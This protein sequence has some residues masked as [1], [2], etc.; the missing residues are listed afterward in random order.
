[1]CHD[2]SSQTGTQRRTFLQTLAG[3]VSA[4]VLP[5]R[6]GADNKR[7]EIRHILPVVSDTEFAIS[8]SL[9]SPRAN[10]SLIVGEHSFAGEQRDS[11]GQFW[12]VRAHGLNP[13]S[14]YQLQLKDE[15]GPLGTPWPLKTFPRPQDAVDS[16][17]LL[18]FTCA[19]GGDGFG[20][21]GRQFFKPHTFRQR[22]FEAALNQQPDAAIA[23]GDHIYWD[24]R[25]GSK[26]GVGRKSV[27]IKYLAG[28]YLQFKYG[29][30][31]RTQALLGT[32]NEKILT[33]IG[34]EQIADL[35]GTRFKSMPTYFVADDHDYFE[36][37]DAD[38][39]LV[40]FPPDEFS[41]AAHAAIAQLYYPPLPNA[42]DKESNRSFGSI[43]Y[44]KL[45]ESPIFDCAGYL[46]LD[47]E[48]AGLIP[49]SVER[50][51][52][53]RSANS[54]ATHFAFAPSH[55]F[56]WTAG[57]WREWYPD[58][59]APKGYD[60]IVANELLA[61]TAGELSTTAKKYLWP[62]GWWN[63]HQRLLTA[64]AERPTSRFILSG[65]IHA[66][67][68]VQIT[69]SGKLDLSDQPLTSF[70]VGPVSTS[71]ATW[72]SAARGIPAAK[73]GWL[74]RKEL[75]TTKEVNGFT[76]FSFNPTTATATLYECGGY[77]LDKAENGSVLA[78][79]D[80]AIS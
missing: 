77:D 50:W 5:K 8:L 54:G 7:G 39:D 42:P 66:Q 53:E 19:G 32:A 9:Y 56:G 70:L 35:Y 64:I 43:V 72:P 80:V 20:I 51:L 55:P 22:L 1:M 31:D 68:A 12:L 79:Y 3:A 25:G 71:E 18:A 6:S 2:Q 76:I 59:V 4:L 21:P 40:T 15:S 67:G 52:I 16:F 10:I 62:R 14:V 34:N 13:D 65:D 44:G 74:N 63:Q 29:E 78:T 38:K 61:D 28:W 69:S 73:P 57:K 60:G 30:F 75:A 17:R 26:P 46:S 27:I 49:K 36:N 58:V 47:G 37:D 45:F 33:R 24:L 23:I 48:D 11:N 41:R